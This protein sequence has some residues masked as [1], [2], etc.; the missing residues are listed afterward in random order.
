[1]EEKYLNGNRMVKVVRNQV[2]CTL[3]LYENMRMVS[4]DTFLNDTDAHQYAVE[5]IGEQSLMGAK[6]LLNESV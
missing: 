1:M 6:K 2:G 3:Y 5:Y 4:Q